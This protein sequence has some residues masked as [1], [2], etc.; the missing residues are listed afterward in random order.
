MALTKELIQ[1]AQGNV[2]F[3]VAFEDYYNHKN[4]CGSFDATRSLSEKSEKIKEAFFAYVE[5]M[6]GVARTEKNADA[7][8]HNPQTQWAAMAILNETIN[9]VLPAYI[10]NSLNPFVDMKY[11]GF[12]D[13]VKFRV[14]PRQLYT[15]SK[16][17]HGERQT[18][19]QKHFESDVVVAP[20]SHIITVYADF[21]RVMAGLED[22]ADFIRM[23]VLSVEVEMTR[24]AIKALSDT[25]NEATYPTEFIHRGPFNSKE[26]VKLA[27]RVQAY[28]FGAKPVFLGT[29]AALMNVL[30]DSAAGFRMQVAGSN[31]AVSIMKDFYGF[32]LYELTQIPTG[33]AD[34]G[35]ELADDALY[36]VS[37]GADKLIKGVVSNA[38]SHSNQY[39]DNADLTSD[40]T[41]T[42]DWNFV[43]LSAAYAAKYII[44]D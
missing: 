42:K 8:A 43:G 35:M 27:Q 40:Y 7:W 19:R 37:P 10:N 11:V 14:K 15:V 32:E 34:F 20:I 44:T 39:L 21:Y 29:R 17:A 28:N 25:L 23:A 31:G 38:M 24:D 2:D 12:G 33:G 9:S 22:I 1:F 18:F 5:D 6:S 41:F 26:A 16:G 3:F 30:P 36:M 13:I 4:N